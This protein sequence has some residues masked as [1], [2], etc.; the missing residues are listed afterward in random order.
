MAFAFSLL[1]PGR[2]LPHTLFLQWA[3]LRPRASFTHSPGLWRG[4]LARMEGAGDFLGFP[5]Q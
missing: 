2:G 5:G 1:L 4:P 3:C